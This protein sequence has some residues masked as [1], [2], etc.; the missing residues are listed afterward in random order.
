MERL[1]IVVFCSGG[2][3]LLR[4]ILEGE[5]TG[6]Y[7]VNKV[8]TDRLCGAEKVASLFGTTTS[9]IDPSDPKLFESEL[10]CAIPPETNLIVLAGFMPIL[11]KEFIESV[12]CPIIN[13]HPSLLPKFGGRGMYGVHVQEAVLA[14]KEAEAG[15]SVHLVTEE[16]DC[17]PVIARKKIAIEPHEDAW[18]LGGRVFREEGPLLVKVINSF[19]SE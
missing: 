10:L 1:K 17:G 9:R 4:S 18:T 15:C 3:G 2:G 14:S 19:C 8:I 13:S 7:S 16:I 6:Q 11:G 12:R 5:P